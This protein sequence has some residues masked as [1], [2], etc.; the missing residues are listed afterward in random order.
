MKQH[1]KTH[2]DHHLSPE[3]V[4][5]VL[6]LFADRDRFFIETIPLPDHLPSAPCALYGPLMGDDPVPASE[7][8]QAPRGDR[9]Y[10]SR[11]C[12]RPLRMVRTITVIAGPHDDIC[13]TCKGEGEHQAGCDDA[14]KLEHH[15]CIVYTMFGGPLAPMEVDDPRL[16]DNRYASI[17]FWAEHAL[18]ATDGV[19]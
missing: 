2:L 18:S 5:F 1:P 19:Q 16:T 13:P 17:A 4:E 8:H 11:L 12:D 15:D 3:H 14:S 7:C 6:A 9:T 10:S